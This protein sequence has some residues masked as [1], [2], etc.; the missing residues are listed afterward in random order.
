MNALRESI[1]DEI[2]VM[3]S[4]NKDSQ[5]PQIV[6]WSLDT[7]LSEAENL[8]YKSE[9]LISEAMKILIVFLDPIHFLDCTGTKFKI[10]Q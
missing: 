2:S 1:T 9:Y 3:Q 5:I 4:S 10:S 8:E 7:I 6:K